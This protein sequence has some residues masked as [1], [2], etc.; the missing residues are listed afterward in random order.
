MK[1]L[2]L[3]LSLTMTA[4]GVTFPDAA[5]KSLWAKINTAIME[6]KPQTAV[7]YLGELEKLVESKQ[8]T[9]EMYEV[10]RV[11]LD[12]LRKY[13]WKDAN[14]Y[15]PK[16]D[17]LNRQIMDNLDHYIEAYPFHQ[18]VDNL[19]YEKIVRI[20]DAEDVKDGRSAEQYQKIR[21]M[22]TLALKEFPESSRL[23][24]F[25]ALI[26]MMDSKSLSFYTSSC[27]VYPGQ[28]VEFKV[29]S[30]NVVASDLMI[31][32]MSERYTLLDAE[33][34][35]QQLK[36]DE[37]SRK[38]E[39]RTI[40]DY[41]GLYNI[42]E[43]TSFSYKFD[44]PG[45]YMVMLRS[46][47]QMCFE[48]LYVSSVALAVREQG[49]R[50]Q[51]YVADA[52]SG[53]PA[54][55]VTVTAFTEGTDG[56][57]EQGA[58]AEPQYISEKKYD[59]DGFT[60]LT[61][62]L[63]RLNERNSE[64][65]A[66]VKGDRFCAPV[67]I[68]KSGWSRSEV[69][70]SYVQTYIFTDRKMYRPD[71]TIQFKLISLTTN[72]EKGKVLG[73]KKVSVSLYAPG[74]SKAAATVEVVTN[75][76]GSASG[77]FY[78]P[79]GNRNGQYRIEGGSASAWV[80]VEEYRD[81]GFRVT[82]P[83]VEDMIVF[84]RPVVQKGVAKGYAGNPVSDARVEY[85]VERYS[86]WYRGYTNEDRKVA[87]GTLTT[88]SSGNF[89]IS[90]VPEAPAA[91][92]VSEVYYQIE[93]KV[94]DMGGETFSQSRTVTVARRPLVFSIQFDG[95]KEDEDYYDAD[96][97]ITLVNKD[98]A[99]T[100]TI[101]VN[102]TDRQLLPLEGRW[103]LLKDGDLKE[104]G[105]F[106]SGEAVFE[107][108][109][110][111]RSGTYELE[112]I[113]E[114]ADNGELRDTSK[115]AFFSPNDRKAPVGGR[116]FF[117]PVNDSD[118]IDFM[119]GTTDELYL[120]V[121]VADDGKTVWSRQLNLKNSAERIE[122]PYR[123]EYKDKVLVSVY[124]I[125]DMKEI[126]TRHEFK[127]TVPSFNFDVKI[128]S[129]RDRTTPNTEETFTLEAPAS[130]AL[131][132]I[133]DITTDRY[134]S[135]GF[136][137]HPIDEYYADMPDVRSNLERRGR[138]Y[139]MAMTKGAM[140]DEDIVIG[141]GAPKR[142][143][144]SA[145]SANKEMAMDMVAAAEE[146]AGLEMPAPEPEGE[147]DTR[148]DF[149]QTLAFIPKL[150]IEDGKPAEVK[151]TTRDGLSTFK[152][153]VLAHTKDLR[154]GTA[155]GEFTV[156]KAVMVQPALP[157][158]A[159]AGDRIVLKAPVSNM[160]AE[161]IK[162]TASIQFADKESGRE[163]TLG[164]SDIEMDIPAGSQQAA[165]W[166]IEVPD[167]IKNLDVT[168]TFRSKYGSDAE[169]HLIEIYPDSRYVTEAESFILGTGVDK[170]AVIRE[171]QKK[172]GRNDAHIRYEEYST[173]DAV[174]DV[175][176]K[177]SAPAR[178][179]MIAWLDCLY[180]NQMRGMT[181]GAD[182]VD[183][184]LSQK[185]AKRLEVMQKSDGGW[186]WFPCC[187]SSDELT[188]LFLDRMYY[189]REL[190]KMPRNTSLNQ[191][192][193]KALGYVDK[194]IFEISAKK[195]YDWRSLIYFFAARMEHPNFAM[196]KDIQNILLDF[197]KKS[198]D[199]GW[200]DVSIMEKAKLC[201]IYWATGEAKAQL[202]LMAS[203]RD[204]A[205]R[206]KT[207]GCYFPNA[208][209]PFRG[210]L[211]TEIYAHSV[212]AQMFAEMEQNDIAQGIFQ[213]LLLQKHNQEW[214]SNM[215]SADAVYV[216]LKYGAK[217]LKFGAVYYT[218]YSPLL[219]VQ[220]SSNEISVKRT[221]FRDGKELKNGD[222]LYV[223]DRIK[224]R[225]D[226]SNTENRSFVEMKADRPA[227][228]YPVD[229]RSY[230]FWNLYCSKEAGATT[231]YFQ[232]LPEEDTWYTEE[233]FVTQE[234]TFNT[235]LVEIESKYAP[236]YRGHTGAFELHTE[237]K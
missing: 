61:Q 50:H 113:V 11:T 3:L 35:V 54:R 47:D 31:F 234:G 233:F 158:F 98:K 18:R 235:G 217:D 119:V 65:F 218:Y 43:E 206:N 99:K 146:S 67:S 231:Y 134:G 38:V 106:T 79:A 189:L 58:L 57:K 237:L 200:S 104:S 172:Y 44:K 151:F 149:A 87:E 34:A 170:D 109:K 8:D 24:D 120:I 213:W 36:K 179:N 107:N 27:V 55:E 166:E 89:E 171:M 236:E 197:L 154:S 128:N 193:E 135:N 91:A 13:N 219:K 93:V 229:E 121:E 188:M 102:N 220:P 16:F 201:T 32:S 101:S 142:M 92:D 30:R 97:N 33:E 187:S 140:V 138:Y 129:L 148:S 157:L 96:K 80:R 210:L 131:V 100:F 164:C 184:A 225:Y 70:R 40:R 212:L 168:I 116:L 192:I 130:E 81:P 177:P 63:F 215:A 41:A 110:K 86:N 94:T 126:E 82:L 71:D 175:L 75:D 132:S 60:N 228:F 221:Y 224:A 185:A 17:G 2:F 14:Q 83:A 180:V 144:M 51:V 52:M 112:C 195:D 160:T 45:I 209:M 46:K 85:T 227:C 103:R 6:D 141:Y 64:I 53:K 156:S 232:V 49:G 174:R 222:R 48:T 76:M 178:N 125:K 7:S 72:G 108:L 145:R 186:G 176:K 183:A 181:A 29:E 139:G 194:R 155:T 169:K 226:I 26:D 115:V 118:A 10:R 78:I 28:E 59:I 211:H 105:S 95:V 205:V 20:K 196:S 39:D 127:R 208:V 203:L 4:A 163:Y 19:I 143:L 136:W 56:K 198:K 68:W 199:Q 25:Q 214:Q 202:K 62:P 223:G 191:Q 42:S 137:F 123:K 207:V 77:S 66:A 23:K 216:L 15:Q 114:T 73:G 1:E 190:G 5:Y 153:L 122:L 74:E 204:Y 159:V 84:G 147:V 182:S 150:E 22:C 88:D 230:G 161:A 152:V 165:S 162:G 117:Y 111:L 21:E 9:L 124:G 173:M 12:Q 133:Y 167:D 37:V 90:F 69:R